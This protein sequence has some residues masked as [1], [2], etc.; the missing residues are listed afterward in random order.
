[1]K[2]FFQ[3]EGKTLKLLEATS[4]LGFVIAMLLFFMRAFKRMNL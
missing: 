3:D 2:C 1:M 4:W